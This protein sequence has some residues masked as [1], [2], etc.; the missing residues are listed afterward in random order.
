[1][2]DIIEIVFEFPPGVLDAGA[3]GIGDLSPSSEPRLDKE[4]FQEEGDLLSE[5]FGEFRAFGSWSNERHVSAEN[6]EELGDFVNA[7]FTEDTSQRRDPGIAIPGGP[8]DPVLFGIGDHGPD[9]V[10]VEFFTATAKAFL[11]VEDGSAM[12]DE[13]ENNSEDE[14]RHEDHADCD[15]RGDVEDTFEG[16]DV[17]ELGGGT[18][19]EKPL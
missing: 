5:L 2:F 19:M 8:L 9:L 14:E 15:R 12:E 11:A 18:G 3:V 16:T 1:M 7:K 17:S 10:E 6:V 13:L 4:A